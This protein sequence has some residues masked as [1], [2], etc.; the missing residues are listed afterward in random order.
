MTTAEHRWRSLL[1]W[2]AL[3][4]APLTAVLVG[5]AA[6][7]PGAERPPLRL[8]EALALGIQRNLD[9][10]L[11]EIAIPVSE[12]EVVAREAEFDPVMEA[13]ADARADKV[14]SAAGG[15]RDP[16]L[17]RTTGADVGVRKRFTT[18]LESRLA[19]ETFRRT[20]DDP[21]TALVPA[22]RTFLVLDLTQPLLRDRGREVNTSALREGR[23]AVLQARYLHLDRALRIGE[24]I[25][26]AYYDLATAHQLLA[27]RVEAR[28]RAEELLA[29]NREKFEAGVV[30]ITEVQQAETAV[31]ARD[32]QVV[33]ARQ[34]ADRVTTRLWDLLEIRRGD[35]GYGAP[36]VT[37]PLPPAPE[38]YPELEEALAVALAERPDLRERL[39]EVENRD[40]RVAFSRNQTL[41]RL[42]LVATLGLNGL[43]GDE[44]EGFSS[45]YDG[46]YL[47]SWSRLPDGDGYQWLAGVRLAYPLGNRSAQA[48]LRQSA[49]EKRQAV[50][51]LKR[52]EGTAEAEVERALVDVRRGLERY[53]VAERF[54]RLAAATLSQEMERLKEGLSD[55]FRVLTFQD[56]LTEAHIRKEAALSDSQ[57]GLAS[58]YRAMGKNLERHGI[59]AELQEKES[60]R[61]HP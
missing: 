7:D 21:G 24:E 55:T 22:Y 12:Q 2:T 51:G 56:D 28:G 26:L 33:V 18:G 14:P 11:Q 4:A 20:T 54:H 23:N 50:Y 45:D 59:V 8:R 39:L 37:E 52:L 31:A 32:E 1:P 46:R 60:E 61:E 9:L 36:F 47:D 35:P 58:L 49:W 13:G 40:L 25:E 48:R 5:A 43:S 42:D 15:G 44:R 41:P 53:R 30:P 19:A 57:K 3:L 16:N 27:Y 34:L 10:R 29:G 17:V 38:D 6:A